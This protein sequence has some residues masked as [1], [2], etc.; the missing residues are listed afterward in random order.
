[1]GDDR[2]FQAVVL[3]ARCAA[4]TTRPDR[5]QRVHTFIR[6]RV[7]PM[8][9]LSLWTFGY[10]RRDDT[11]CAWLIWRPNVGALPQTSQDRA[12]SSPS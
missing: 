10:Q 2:E 5:R 11:L 9:T 8:I 1:M 7:F 4:F 6:R 3:A 12:T